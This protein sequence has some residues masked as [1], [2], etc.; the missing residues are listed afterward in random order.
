MG[1]ARGGQPGAAE[2]AA[3]RTGRTAS[4]LRGRVAP[5]RCVARPK[6]PLCPPPLHPPPLRTHRPCAPPLRT[7][8]LCPPTA[9]PLR[10]AAASSGCV[11]RPRTDPTAAQQAAC[12]M[13]APARAP[14]AP[15][16]APS[17]PPRAR[18]LGPARAA[19]SRSPSAARPQS[20]R[21][22]TTGPCCGQPCSTA[23]RA[24]PPS[25]SS[26]SHRLTTSF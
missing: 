25:S 16:R 9:P 2:G 1:P 8:R 14:R 24:P 4:A 10:R 23:M 19:P 12:R 15:M 13:G 21:G 6:A 7:G 11:A 17:P 5:A 18:A 22:L 3:L 26:S 20:D